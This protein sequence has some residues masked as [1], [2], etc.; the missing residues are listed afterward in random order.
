[1]KLRI[2]DFLVVILAKYKLEQSSIP[3]FLGMKAYRH[4]FSK[5][6]FIFSI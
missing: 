6:K 3:A 4:G 5:N 1:M 2:T